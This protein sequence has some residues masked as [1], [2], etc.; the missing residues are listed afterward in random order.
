MTSRG[1]RRSASAASSSTPRRASGCASSSSIPRRSRK[2]R[3]PPEPLTP[4]SETPPQTS[5]PLPAGS[6]EGRGSGLDRLGRRLLVPLALG[7][8]V[9]VGLA[10][11]ANPRELARSL[12]VFDLRLL[13]PVLALSLFNYGL[14]WIRWEIYLRRLGVTLSKGRSLAVFL[15]GFLLS[16]TPGKAGELGK[17]WLVRELGGGKA[18]RVVSAVL[19]ERVTDVLGTFVLIALGTFP[20]V[21]GPWIAASGGRR[22][23]S[24]SVV[25]LTWRRG[26]E[27]VFAI[28]RRMPV[29]G[30]RVPHL[31]EMYDRLRELLSPGLAVMAIGGGDG[32][33]GGGGAGLLAG[34]PQ[35][36]AEGGPAALGLQLHRRERPRRALDAP[37]RPGSRRRLPR[38]PPP[39]PG[40]RHRGR[41]L[42]HPGHPRG[43]ALVRGPAR[44]RRAPLRGAVAGGGAARAW[45]NARAGSTPSSARTPGRTAGSPPSPR[46]SLRSLLLGRRRGAALGAELGAAG[47]GAAGLADGAGD[48]AEVRFFIQSTSC[49]FSKAWLF[50]ASAW[51]EAISSSR[52]GRTTRRGPPFH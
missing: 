42:D 12:R 19:A 47:L 25:L 35:L 11:T 39:R 26:A 10:L 9:V 32:G 44:P 20:L 29:I 49:A 51:A 18:M 48:L 28:L 4:S 13:V 34:G 36:R 52:S 5:T 8:L 16:V 15:V 46:R 1:T 6:P 37:R 2:K 3:R 40:P 45:I 38:R 17:A 50:A 23:R 24:P 22:G 14:R 43:D 30:P 21:G 7:V 27:W 33:L 31:V 41:Q